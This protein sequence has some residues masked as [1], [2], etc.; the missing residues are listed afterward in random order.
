MTTEQLLAIVKA[1]EGTT[2]EAS[3][4]NHGLR[5]THWLHYWAKRFYDEGCDS[6]RRRVSRKQM[7]RY[8]PTTQW[9]I[10]G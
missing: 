3:I 7:L 1:A 8:Y 5:S 2:I 6:R 4:T 9:T 10:D